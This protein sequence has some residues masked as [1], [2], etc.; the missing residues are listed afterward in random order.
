MD[1]PLGTLGEGAALSIAAGG[2]LFNPAA[3][4]G[5]ARARLRLSVGK[6]DAPGDRDVGGE[7]LS[8]VYRPDARD[9]FGISFAHMGVSGID[10]TGI[11]GPE[12]QGTVPYGTYV[13]SVLAAR[14]L[15]WRFRDHVALGV[16][17]RYRSA[18]ADTVRGST[19]AADV[20]LY[21]DRLFGRL[22]ARIALASYLWLP[23]RESVERPG[24]HVAADA[25]VAGPDAEHEGR[26]GA[27]YDRTRGGRREAFVFVAGRWRYV[28]ARAGVARAREFEDP[29]TSTRL[30]L[31]FHASRFSVGVGREDS[32][33][34]FGSMYQFTL[35][36]QI[37]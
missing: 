27:S 15:G 14:R 20:G 23:G 13:V 29:Q 33:P 19:G 10:R 24:A 4:L 21:A 32:Q 5:P 16:A 7:L 12:T 30:G 17:G 35:S 26:L 28:E 11:D 6:L 22:D 9:A 1:F 18:H 3:I 37:K 8:A 31:A 36:T 25:R 34:S 2:G